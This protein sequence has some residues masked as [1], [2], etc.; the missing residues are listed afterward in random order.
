MV[1]SVY[2]GNCNCVLAFPLRVRNCNFSLGLSSGSDQCQPAPLH[3]GTGEHPPPPSDSRLCP[4]L[5]DS[6]SLEPSRSHS[7]SCVRD[8]PGEIC[9]VVV[10]FCVFSPYILMIRTR[11]GTSARCVGVSA[12]HR[13][14]FLTSKELDW[15]TSVVG[16]PSSTAATTVY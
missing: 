16:T 13:R 12:V 8:E 9:F 3:V 7:F 14:C 11:L 4:S 2:H 6:L 1:L 5:G 15:D 10:F